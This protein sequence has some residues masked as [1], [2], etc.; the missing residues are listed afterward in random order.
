MNLAEQEVEKET[1]RRHLGIEESNWGGD[2]ED[3]I[4]GH[5]CIENYG[6]QNYDPPDIALEPVE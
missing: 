1:I 2:I 4:S 6:R 5:M 3:C